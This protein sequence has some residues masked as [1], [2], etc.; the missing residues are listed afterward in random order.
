MEKVMAKRSKLKTYENKLVLS[1]FVKG[2]QSTMLMEKMALMIM[3]FGFFTKRYLIKRHGRT[4]EYC[5]SQSSKANVLIF[6]P[7][8]TL[9]LIL[10]TLT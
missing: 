3:M 9:L 7:A 2:Q 5:V 6:L 1:R 8:P 4:G 10:A